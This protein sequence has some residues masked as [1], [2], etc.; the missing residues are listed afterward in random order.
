[1]AGGVHRSFGSKSLKRNGL[2]Y[3][4]PDKG[5]ANERDGQ[6]K[7]AGLAG[8]HCTRATTVKAALI[9]KGVEESFPKP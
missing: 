6:G 7:R 5:M 8:G 9:G 1:M 4:V 2:R 3:L